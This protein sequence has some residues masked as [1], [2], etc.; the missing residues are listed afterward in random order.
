MGGCCTGVWLGGMY[1]Y[2][3]VCVYVCMH[4]CA[5]VCTCVCMLWYGKLVIIFKIDFQ[6]IDM[7]M[8][9]LLK[10]S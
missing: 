7:K 9:V 4:V 2:M 5:Y 1:V 3:H 8:K 10:S 6:S